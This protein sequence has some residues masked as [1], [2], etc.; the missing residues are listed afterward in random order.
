MRATLFLCACLLTAPLAG[1]S[2][3]RAQD[4]PYGFSDGADILRGFAA[5]DC[6]DG[7]DKIATYA[8]GATADGRAQAL[9]ASALLSDEGLCVEQDR[10]RAAE[11]YWRALH[12]SFYL[13][14]AFRLALACQ[15]GVDAPAQAC[16]APLLEIGVEVMRAAD[17]GDAV[18]EERLQRRALPASIREALAA[19]PRLFDRGEADV[20]AHA[21]ALAERAR[22]DRLWRAPALAWLD[23]VDLDVAE[24]LPRADRL[25]LRLARALVDLTPWA[26]PDARYSANTMLF[27]L[28]NNEEYDAAVLAA[29]RLLRRH[30]K[31]E[32][33]RLEALSLFYHA[34]RLG[35]SLDAEIAAL[36]NRVSEDARAEARWIDANGHTPLLIDF[37]GL[38]TDIPLAQP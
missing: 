8:Q 27:L 33:K 31:T 14:P 7:G 36:E 9:I 24:R 38:I 4:S 37:D 11:I 34:R 25:R 18:L 12:E 1:P 3:A 13:E 15:E 28:V 23:R 32:R 19:A 6:K 10:T 2:D 16:A 21:L 29:A 22:N 35:A 5:L 20:L 26:S 17:F 30:A